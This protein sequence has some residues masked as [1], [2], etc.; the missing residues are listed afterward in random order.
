MLQAAVEK[1]PTIRLGSVWFPEEMSPRSYRMANMVSAPSWKFLLSLVAMKHGVLIR[2]IL[3]PGRQTNIAA[4]RHEAM[5]LIYRHTKA[6]ASQ[7]GRYMQRD[8]TTVLHALRKRGVT[9]KLVEVP[10]WCAAKY[11]PK[12]HPSRAGEAFRP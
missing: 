10:G 8:H 5:D 12:S 9:D 3:G 7:V 2:D 1:L 6:S 11:R 4:A